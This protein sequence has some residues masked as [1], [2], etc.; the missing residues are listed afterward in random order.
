MGNIWEGISE[1]VKAYEKK[2]SIVNSVNGGLSYLLCES[3]GL[4][5]KNG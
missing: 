3:C 5:V 4:P 1:E 2:I